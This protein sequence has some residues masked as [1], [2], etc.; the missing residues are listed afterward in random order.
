MLHHLRPLTY[1]NDCNQDKHDRGQHPDTCLQE[2]HNDSSCSSD[3]EQDYLQHGE[4]YI[5]QFHEER[6]CVRIVDALHRQVLLLGQVFHF[7]YLERA[8][9]EGEKCLE[10]VFVVAVN[11]I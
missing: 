1:H 4:N 6:P 5:D 2:W 9:G 3:Q 11:I 10:N 8:N 7:C